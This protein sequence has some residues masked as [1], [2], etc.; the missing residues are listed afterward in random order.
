MNMINI[1]SQKD[2]FSGLMFTIL[3]IA[4]A[5]GASRY[6]FGS[7]VN[8]GPGYFPLILGILLSILGGVIIFKALVGKTKDGDKIG[9]IGWRPLVFIIS[10]NLIFGVAVG[11]LP[12]I[13]LPPM[14][15]IV[16]IYALTFIASLAG[17]E[18]NFKGV[19]VLA[20]VLAIINYLAFVHLIN[21]QIAV[22]PTFITR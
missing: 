22:W 21:L 8:M 13:G 16:G 18:F 19:M 15:M 3:G 5:W 4:F 9:S 17:E 10:A 7:G 12:S 1:K 11:G 6:R 14:G 2:F 20:T